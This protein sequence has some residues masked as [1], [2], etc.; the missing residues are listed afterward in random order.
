MSLPQFLTSLFE[1]GRVRVSNDALPSREELLAADHVLALF[2][3]EYRRDLPLDTP[4]FLPNVGGWA[5]GMLYR[6]CAFT[7]FRDVHAERLREELSIPCPEPLS[8]PV[9]Y[10][11]DLTFRFLPD[12][13]KFAKSASQADPLLDLLADWANQWPL[14]SVGIPGVE[15]PSSRLDGIVE[16]AGLLRLYTDRIIAREDHS[17]L[18]DSRVHEA[19]QQA[20]GLFPEL[21]PQLAGCLTAA[22]ADPEEPTHL[23][24]TSF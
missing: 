15:I 9:H 3:A 18:A 12:L 11:V 17:R 23:E 21:A 7:V 22:V 13:V 16:H 19:V 8:P 2:E 14:S 6:A 1:D 20:L 5:S 10:T 4:A 24:E